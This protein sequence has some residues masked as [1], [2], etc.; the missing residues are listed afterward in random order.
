MGNG[1]GGAEKKKKQVE[2]EEEGEGPRRRIKKK[3][4]KKTQ[5]NVKEEKVHQKEESFLQDKTYK[6]PGNKTEVCNRRER[7]CEN[8]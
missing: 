2:D 5:E 7:I 4:K 1:Q 6:D 3:R 8:N